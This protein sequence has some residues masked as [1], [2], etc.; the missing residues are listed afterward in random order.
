MHGEVNSYHILLGA[1][2]KRHFIVQDRYAWNPMAVYLHPARMRQGVAEVV[3]T[4][5]LGEPP[6]CPFLRNVTRG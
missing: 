6:Q 5:E 2:V 3:R 1:V 4:E